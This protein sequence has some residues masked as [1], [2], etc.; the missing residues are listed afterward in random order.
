M[1]AGS[2]LL[3]YSPRKGIGAQNYMQDAYHFWGFE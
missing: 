1:A 2:I 3:R